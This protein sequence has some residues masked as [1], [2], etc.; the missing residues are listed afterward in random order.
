MHQDGPPPARVSLTKRPWLDFRTGVRTRL[1]AWTMTHI[2]RKKHIMIVCETKTE[3]RPTAPGILIFP[4]L[5][6]AKWCGSSR[7]WLLS[8]LHTPPFPPCPAAASKFSMT[9]GDDTHRILLVVAG[10]TAKNG[11]FVPEH[12]FISNSLDAFLVQPI[13]G[14]MLAR[15]QDSPCSH[16]Y[17]ETSSS[18]HTRRIVKSII[19][20]L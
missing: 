19:A 20:A 4:V 8:S 16:H 6:H 14:A 12:L 10:G 17:H 15:T 9:E 2:Y 18:L 1:A 11:A 13:T 3:T 7:L 5:R